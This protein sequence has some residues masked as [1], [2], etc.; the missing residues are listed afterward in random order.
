MKN[1]RLVDKRN[2]KQIEDLIHK[3]KENGS[4]ND[5]EKIELRNLYREH[6]GYIDD[7]TSE[8]IGIRKQKRGAA[9]AF[10]IIVTM[11]IMLLGF[12]S[13]FI[14]NTK[15][16][17]RELL[18][19]IN[20]QKSSFEELKNNNTELSNTI[21]RLNS[22]INQLQIK[23]NQKPTTVYVP[24]EPAYTPPTYTNCND[25]LFGGFSCTTY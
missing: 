12:S 17:N 1:K 20:S 23:L 4:L 9:K 2:P 7:N 25:N 14:Y 3:L 8:Y 24:S 21:F 10:Y 19:T 13:I 5:L 22:E 6:G 15:K 18:N 16:S 11:F